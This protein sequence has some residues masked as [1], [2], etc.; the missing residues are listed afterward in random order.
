MAIIKCPECEKEVSDTCKKCINCGRKLK[1]DKNSISKMT[2]SGCV[3]NIIATSLII[4]SIIIIF[5][6]NI[7]SSATHQDNNTQQSNINITVGTTTE[8]YTQDSQ[9]MVNLLFIIFITSILAISILTILILKGIGN[10]LILSIIMFVLN[11]GVYSFLLYTFDN[12]CFIVLIIVPIL[13]TIGSIL[14][15]IGCFLGNKNDK[16][17]V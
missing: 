4:I 17:V 14:C 10:K 13:Y 12:C 15:I 11:I 2:K 9:T 1:R 7:F 16:K 5:M 3:V 8:P 6:I